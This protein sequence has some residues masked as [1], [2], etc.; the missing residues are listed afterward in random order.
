[1]TILITLTI[2][3]TDTGPFN[4]YSNLDGYTSAFEVGVAKID[5]VAGYI[6]GIVP[7]GTTIIKVVS[8]NP[9]CTNDIDIPLTLTTTTTTTIANPAT[10][11][12][13]FDKLIT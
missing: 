7:D 9:I 1:M 10:S 12:L 3:G 6:S 13:R 8:D 5:L 2:A 4:L 11:I